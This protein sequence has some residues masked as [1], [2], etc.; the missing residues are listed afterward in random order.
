MDSSPPELFPKNRHFAAT[1]NN[2]AGSLQIVK[3]HRIDLPFRE[4]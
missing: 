4:E 3:Q 1:W 2:F